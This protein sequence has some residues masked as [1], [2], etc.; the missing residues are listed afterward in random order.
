MSL[1]KGKT[2]AALAMN[3]QCLCLLLKPQQW[4]RASVAGLLT[5]SASRTKQGSLEPGKELLGQH[6]LL[7]GLKEPSAPD[8]CT[9]PRG[10]PASTSR[11]RSSPLI[12]T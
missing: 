5:L 3:A 6:H 1:W 7:W 4:G 12:N 9:Y 2:L 10:P 11:S 8:A